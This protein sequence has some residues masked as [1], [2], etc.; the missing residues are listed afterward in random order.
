M[1]ILYGTPN[2]IVS[3]V[4]LMGGRKP[5]Q[6]GMGLLC[7]IFGLRWTVAP[8]R[9]SES[10][11]CSQMRARFSYVLMI[12]FLPESTLPTSWVTVKAHRFLHGIRQ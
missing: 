6:L 8:Y 4:R 5:Y 2:R 7:G 12:R 10:T 1:L 11:N 3:D 9:A